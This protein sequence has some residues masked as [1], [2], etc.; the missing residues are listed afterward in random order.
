MKFTEELLYFLWK[1][2]LFDQKKLFTTSGEL[3]EI[4]SAGI[5]NKGA[6][7]DFEQAKIRI[8]KTTWVGNIEMHL[9]SSDWDN[10][11]HFLDKAYNNVILHVVWEDDKVILRSDGTEVPTL[12]LQGIEFK[13]I[14]LRYRDLMENLNWIPCEN[15]L[16]LI[17]DV[18]ID[19]WLSRVLIER[20]EE[21]SKT[22]LALL[23]EYR[24]SWDDAFYVL[25]ARN[26][27][28]KIN[29]LPFELLARSLPQSILAKHKNNSLQI[30]ALIFGQAGFL[31]AQLEDD[32]PKKMQREYHF[33]RKKYGLIPIDQYLWKF[34]RLRPQNF[35]T[36]RLAQFAALVGKSSHLFS[37]IIE[38]S[39]VKK[40]HLLFNNLMINPYWRDHYRFGKL[41]PE[42]SKHLGTNSVNNI[43]LNSIVLFIF[44]YGKQTGQEKFIHKSITILESLPFEI[45]QVTAGFNKIGLKTGG[46]ETSQ[47]L[48]QLKKSY[49]DAKR[50]LDCS[51]GTKLIKKS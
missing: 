44:T 37:R 45:N 21:R 22:I 20:L 30:E 48:L 7:P 15:Q 42:A 25:L 50:C 46:A 41:A 4:I 47:A 35:P 12:V 16:A 51:I 49:C 31:T 40:L 24:G 34:L 36:I 29:A 8:G 32:Y 19:S 23:K 26:F 39:D 2:R 3:L 10:H 6:G 1:F 27:G 28:F 18:H 14:E 9:R 17:E 38:I 33:L 13:D 11:K 43:L 5:H